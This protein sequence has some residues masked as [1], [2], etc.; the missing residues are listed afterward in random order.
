[1]TL[2]HFTLR[3]FLIKFWPELVA[4]VAPVNC[5]LANYVWGASLVLGIAFAS[6]CA[7]AGDGD[8]GFSPGTFAFVDPAVGYGRSDFGE[9][10]IGPAVCAELAGVAVATR[11]RD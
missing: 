3:S 8:R 1:V 6:V 5:V 11:S 9:L 7:L 10:S 2:K 4:V